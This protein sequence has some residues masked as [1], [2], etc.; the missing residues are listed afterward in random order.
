[1]IFSSNMQS[2]EYKQCSK[3]NIEILTMSSSGNT[4]SMDM[5]CMYV[6]NPSFNQR[7]FH[8]RMVTRFPNH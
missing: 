1:M 7:S 5:Y 3:M 8:H 4:F 6:A 2:R